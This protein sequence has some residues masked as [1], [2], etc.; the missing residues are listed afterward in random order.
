MIII[1]IAAIGVGY[2][3]W[4]LYMLLMDEKKAELKSE[5]PVC[6]LNF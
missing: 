1:G 4:A 6:K 5:I 2:F 3:L